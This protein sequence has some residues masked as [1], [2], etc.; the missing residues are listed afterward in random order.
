MAHA[1]E[2][3]FVHKHLCDWLDSQYDDAQEWMDAFYAIYAL[4]QDDPDLLKDHS[5][6][7]I[8]LMASAG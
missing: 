3:P 7:E 1:L 5:W 8:N 6:S 2:D 4:L